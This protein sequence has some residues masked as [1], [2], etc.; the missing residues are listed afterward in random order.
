MNGIC[1]K[2]PVAHDRF[3]PARPCQ[4]WRGRQTGGV[5]IAPPVIREVDM[6]AAGHACLLAGGTARATGIGTGSPSGRMA[7]RANAASAWAREVSP[8]A[9]AEHRFLRIM[10]IGSSDRMSIPSHCLPYSNLAQ[11][12][13]LPEGNRISLWRARSAI[14]HMTGPVPICV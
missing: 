3:R 6:R 13:P 7:R 2:A 5:Q 12:Q 11:I 1:P 10:F 9:R 14:Q 4:M 8:A